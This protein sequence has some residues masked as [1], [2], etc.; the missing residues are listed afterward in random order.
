MGPLDKRSRY[1]KAHMRDGGVYVLS[2]WAV[3]EAARTVS[4]EGKRYDAQRRAVAAGRQFFPLDEVALFETNV[5]TQSP[6]V[7]ALAL[8]TGVSLA[9]TVFCAA[10]VKAC[11]GSCPTF[12]LAEGGDWTLR[13]EGFS[14][15]VA[16]VLEATDID[17][18]PASAGGGRDFEIRLRNEA[19]ET[20]V[21]R[22]ANLLAVPRDGGAVV[23]DTHGGFWRA[24]ALSPPRA[25][26]AA[27]GDCLDILADTDGRERVSAADDRDL[28][29]RET[30]ELE[31]ATPPPSS[32]LGIVITSRHT[33]LSTYVFYQQL[34][35]LGSEAS[36]W[37]ARLQRG[38]ARAA[39]ASEAIAH[40]LGR[41]DVLV[42][43]RSGRWTPIG[44]VG[45]AGPLAADV[46]M[47]P[48]PSDA[49]MPVR[50]RLRGTKGLWR[51]DAVH[52]AIDVERVEPIR[53]APAEVEAVDGRGPRRAPSGTLL[54]TLPGDEYALRYR[55]PDDA[56][57]YQLFLE[58]RGYYLE[59]MRDEWMREQNLRRAALMVTEPHKALRLLAPEFKKHE[60][61]MEDAFWRSR[62]VR[63]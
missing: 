16:P 11:F 3:D 63:Q 56:R 33:L 57:S 29:A 12:Y 50:V 19:L 20:H 5:P 27:E 45:E 32:S 25:C 13:A 17:A 34:A 54:T 15:S 36:A 49:A 60:P 24:Q 58:T 41:V 28:A 23:Q 51:L 6:A 48:V 44:A 9:A 7:Q 59:W 8:I 43:T 30:L 38:D 22:F 4:G 37:L 2:Q 46:Q 61:L 40:A 52:L 14:S 1:L 31:F 47:L 55:L 62:Y 26:H 42:E 35:Y 10:N 21:V 53:L 18:L 39:A